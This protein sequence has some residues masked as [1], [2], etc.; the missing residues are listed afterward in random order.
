[1]ANC[2]S[3]LQNVKVKKE[4]NVAE[5]FPYRILND[6]SQKLK[7]AEATIEKLLAEHEALECVKD[8]KIN[9][10]KQTISD[11]VYENNRYH[12]A[13]SYC[14]VCTS[15]DFSY[16]SVSEVSIKAST[17]VTSLDTLEP[18]ISPVLCL[19][20]PSSA[21]KRQADSVIKIKDNNFISRMVKTLNKLE[22]KYT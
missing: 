2:N 7:V 5:K 10:L 21:E 6:L 12:L 3:L 18:S 17:P 14:T 22:T 8:V 16:A 4:E 9:N 11:L 19:G 13:I 20:V 1:M 15:D